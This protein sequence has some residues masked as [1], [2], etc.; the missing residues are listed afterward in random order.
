VRERGRGRGAGLPGWLL[1]CWAGLGPGH[2]PSWAAGFLFLYFFCA[3]SIS[4]FVFSYSTYRFCKTPS[5]EFKPL[6]EVLQNSRQGFKPTTNMF[7]DPKQ[8]FY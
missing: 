6:S 7:S 3:V 1:P 5:N 8:D 4:Y 2:G